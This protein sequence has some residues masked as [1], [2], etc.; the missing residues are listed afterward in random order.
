MAAVLAL[1]RHAKA[2]SLSGVSLPKDLE[3]RMSNAIAFLQAELQEWDVQATENVG[4]EYLLPALL[5]LLEQDG[6]S[7]NFP[8]RQSLMAINKQKLAKFDPRMLYS[9]SK[10][11]PIHSLEAFI[12]KIDFDKVRHQKDFGSMLASPSSTA[13]YLMHCSQWDDEAEAYLRVCLAFG[14]GKGNG[15]VPCAFPITIFELT[16]VTIEHATSF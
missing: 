9:T 5:D 1:S 3:S 13:A 2:P 7:F 11:T 10:S 6:I 12:G 15:A 8:G 16:W 4:F 14:E